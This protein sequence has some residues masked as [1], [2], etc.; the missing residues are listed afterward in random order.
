LFGTFL[1]VPIV[2]SKTGV[3]LLKELSSSISLFAIQNVEEPMK[4][5]RSSQHD[6][7]MI[8]SQRWAKS[9]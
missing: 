5:S 3:R 1:V 2:D 7:V 4:F 6:N 9:L 8:K